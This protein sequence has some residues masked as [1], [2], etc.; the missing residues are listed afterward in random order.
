MFV[1]G[2]QPFIKEDTV[3]KLLNLIDQRKENIIACKHGEIIGAPAIIN[4][5]YKDE[6]YSLMGDNGAKKLIM[7][8]IDDTFLFDLSEKEFIDIDTMEDIEK[9]SDWYERHSNH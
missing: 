5:K 3:S 7:N 4:R 2:D 9:W 8:H 6:L 1:L